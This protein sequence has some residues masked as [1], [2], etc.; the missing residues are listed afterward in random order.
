MAPKNRG[1]RASGGS[2]Y[3]SCTL[4]GGSAALK[5]SS[6]DRVWLAAGR[7]RGA[8]EVPLEN[9]EI[10]IPDRRYALENRDEQDTLRKD[11]SSEKTTAT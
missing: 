2:V 4:M 11:A 3:T 1:V 6:A 5:A 10:T 7:G 9:F 8:N